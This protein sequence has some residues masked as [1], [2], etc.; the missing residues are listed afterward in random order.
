MS[1]QRRQVPRLAL[2]RSEAAEALGVG[3]TT[4][5]TRIAPELRVVR[6]GKVRLYSVRELERWLEANAERVLNDAA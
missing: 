4:F 6:P 1:G 5:K 3:I 2:T